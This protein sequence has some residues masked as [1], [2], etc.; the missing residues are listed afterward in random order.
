MTYFAEFI[1]AGLE[2]VS[3]QW[4]RFLLFGVVLMGLGVLCV[5]KANTATTF[6][7]L[8]LGWVLAISGV[9]WLV[10]A[11]FALNWHG[12]FFFLLNAVI[13]GVTGFLLIRHP[14]AGAA[15]VTML[16]A[17]LF[18]IGGVFRGV[19]ATV[20]QFPRW[21]WTLLSG[22]VAVAFGIYLLAVWPAAS[23][24]LV[25]LIIGVDLTFD[26]AALVGFATAIH[27]LPAP[28]KKKVAA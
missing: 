15:A 17:A 14:D 28:A 7:I 13:R 16:L 12:F 19:A 23:P 25:G 3:K 2:Q 8:A 18:I 4:Y 11:L 1:E 21:G 10:N 26:G 9:V 20:L 27:S 6:S 22:L 5:L 24:F